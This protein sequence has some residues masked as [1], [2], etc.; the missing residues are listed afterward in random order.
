MVNLFVAITD[1]SWFELLSHEPLN[2]G[3]FGQHNGSHSF[4]AVLVGQLFLFELHAQDDTMVVSGISLL[5][6]TDVHQ[7]FN[8][9]YVT[10]SGD[11]HFQVSHRLNAHFENRR[12]YYD[13]HGYPVRPPQ[14]GYAAPCI[15]A[16]DWH[17]KLRCLG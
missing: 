13:L 2:D 7:L 9:G 11:H 8:L 5:L 15:D 16:L 1:R 10:V 3:N 14:L 17:R 4:G 12:H 6:R